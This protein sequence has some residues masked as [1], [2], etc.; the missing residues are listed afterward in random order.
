MKE[1]WVQI[2]GQSH[3]CLSHFYYPSDK[4]TYRFIISSAISGDELRL[5][6]SNQFSENDVHIGGITACVCDS[7][8]KLTGEITDVTFGG[9][10]SFVIEKGSRILCDR[11]SLCLTDGDF[12][13][14]SIYVEKGA[15]K[16]GNLLDSIRLITASG[17]RTGESFIEN[18]RRKRDK[19]IEIAGKVFNLALHKPLPLIESVEVR[20]HTGARAITVFGDSLS[21]QGFWTNRFEERIREAFPGSFTVINKSIMGNRILHDFSPRFP[22]RG[23]FGESAIKRLQRDVLDFP[24]TE[25]VILSVGINDFVQPGTIVAPKTEK[26]EAS[27]VLSAVLDITDKIKSAGKKVIVF[28]TPMFGACVDAR[29]YKLEA[30]KDYNRYLKENEEQFYCLFDQASVVA[31]PE[32]P[33]YTKA[34]YLGNDKLHYNEAGGRRVAESINLSVFE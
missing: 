20:N 23:L 3:S 31:D 12:A 11:C 17:N 24:D 10:R 34:E 2:W 27:Q 29:P 30:A 32:K 16:S 5:R 4:K 13:A 18:E 25:F 26:S 21:Q 8:G 33:L 6:L 15:L 14:L 7:T 1:N 22:C 28:N 9:K 19:V